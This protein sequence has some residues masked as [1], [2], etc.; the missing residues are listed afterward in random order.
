MTTD[1]NNNNN[2]NNIIIIII[3]IIKCAQTN[4]YSSLLRCLNEFSLVVPLDYTLSISLAV[5]HY[6]G[7][8]C[9]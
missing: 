6:K 7:Q 2:N 5:I 3:I 8:D 4:V 9:I 1:N